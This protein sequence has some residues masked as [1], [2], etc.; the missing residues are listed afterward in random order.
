[1][2]DDDKDVLDAFGPP[3]PPSKPV[4]P[5]FVASRD[6]ADREFA[7]RNVCVGCGKERAWNRMGKLRRVVQIDGLPWH[8]HCFNTLYPGRRV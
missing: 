2:I 6:R 7:E 5:T 1:M 8:L 4:V 3:N